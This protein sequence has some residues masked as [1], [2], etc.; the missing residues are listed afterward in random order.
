MA[1]TA[2]LAPPQAY[3]LTT[4]PPNRQSGQP[5]NRQSGQ[6]SDHV[7]VE[8]AS[9][10]SRSSPRPQTCLAFPR[11]HTPH[12]LAAVSR[13]SARLLS[14]PASP[15]GRCLSPT[16]AS[17]CSWSRR[18]H[19]RGRGRPGEAGWGRGLGGRG[20]YPNAGDGHAGGAE[21]LQLQRWA[22]LTHMSERAELDTS[23]PQIW[24]SCLG[25]GGAARHTTAAN[26][27]FT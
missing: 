4:L 16:L 26:S 25:E 6:L 24:A 8:E 7:Q 19:V 3:H 15:G 21:W 17:S 2:S 11:C 14:A 10:A 5:S 13:V 18:R 27:T 9:S 1:S 23:A 20:S 12:R 22:A